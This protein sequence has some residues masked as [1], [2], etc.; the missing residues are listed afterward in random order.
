MGDG[1]FSFQ[2][3]WFYFFLCHHRYFDHDE[4]AMHITDTRDFK[5]AQKSGTHESNGEI[6]MKM[7]CM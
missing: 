6:H 2:H 3:L 7:V 5:S 4:N 1:I